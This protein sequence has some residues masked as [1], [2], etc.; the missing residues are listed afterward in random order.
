MTNI[1]EDFTPTDLRYTL[2]AGRKNFEN[3]QHLRDV[4]AANDILRPIPLSYSFEYNQHMEYQA[5]TLLE[6]IRLQKEKKIN[7]LFSTK[8]L[9]D[10]SAY[11]TPLETHFGIF[12]NLVL[13]FASDPKLAHELTNNMDIFGGVL[14]NE[15]DFASNSVND[16]IKTTAEFDAKT[17]EFVIYSAKGSAKFCQ[18]FN[19]FGSHVIIM[20]KLVNGG[21]ALGNYPILVKLRDGKTGEVQRGIEIKWLGPSLGHRGGREYCVSFDNLR[22]PL[23]NHLLNKHLTIEE[24]GVSLAQPEMLLDF[25]TKVALMQQRLL[26]SYRAARELSKAV[27]LVTKYTKMRTQFKT[28][29]TKGQERKIFDYQYNKM[30]IAK[31]LTN[32]IV[33]QTALSL[34]NDKVAMMSMDLKKNGQSLNEYMIFTD[35]IHALIYEKAAENIE[36]LREGTGGMGFLKFSGIPIPH[37]N[38]IAGTVAACPFK[39]EKYLALALMLINTDLNQKSDFFRFTSARLV[40]ENDAPKPILKEDSHYKNINTLF[41]L[42]RYKIL[43]RRGSLLKFRD[44]KS[45]SELTKEALKDNKFMYEEAV[46]L[47]KDFA[48]SICS[49][50]VYVLLFKFINRD[51]NTTIAVILHS[52]MINNFLNDLRIITENTELISEDFYTRMKDDEAK[53]A[54]TI[55]DIAEKLTQ[56]FEYDAEMLNSCFENTAEETYETLLNLS[57]NHN[58]RNDP[59]VHAEIRQGLIE[60]LNRP[61][62]KL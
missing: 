43:R 1:R 14:L 28:M 29:P 24:K 55:G 36:G 41:M 53:T 30:R 3:Y 34:F 44:D 39:E 23:K 54:D 19:S 58:L 6:L 49:S 33:F 60:Y 8:Y 61:R 16:N 45:L 38:I 7:L 21:E 4:F 25:L 20:C 37:E 18:Y 12:R 5:K 35:A 32:A 10:F 26:E 27:Y 9:S 62:E 59:K 40:N 31:S 15:M 42:Y 2:F 46:Q 47:G 48:E 50:L 17:Q 22:V 56:A 13:Y 51:N 57:K 52:F 11:T